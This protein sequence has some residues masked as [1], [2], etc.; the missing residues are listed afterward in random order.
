[1]HQQP[2][3]FLHDQRPS[4]QPIDQLV[5][6]GRGENRVERIAAMRLSMAGRNR[7][8]MKIVIAE[9]GHR[10]VAER[11]DFAQ[12]GE[13]PGSAIDEVAN[14]PQPIDGARKADRVEE[15][16]QLG[17]TTLDVADRVMCHERER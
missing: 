2:V 13:R 11:D 8:Q 17:V 4:C 9:H 12:H 7:Q 15:L 1:M 10:R 5:A 16:T 14:Q 3:V 6:I